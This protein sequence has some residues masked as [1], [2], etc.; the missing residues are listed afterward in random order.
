MTGRV[1]CPECGA[2]YSRRNDM[3]R[4]RH[5]K[6]LSTIPPHMASKYDDACGPF[7]LIAPFTGIISAMTGAGKTVWVQ[8]LLEN[9]DT[10]INPPP[11]RIVWCY[12]RWQ[13]TY[14]VMQKTIPGI[15]F[16]RGIPEHIDEDWYFDPQ[17]NFWMILC[18]TWDPT[19]V[20]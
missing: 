16:V 4:H 5:R 17:I 3:E 6:H 8:H 13:P 7:Q 20:F 15:E 12:A 18:R 19:N 11:Q 2:S 14:D 1:F 10:M 9:A